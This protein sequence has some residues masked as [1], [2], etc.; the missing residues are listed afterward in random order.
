MSAEIVIR[1]LQ[2]TKDNTA[3]RAREFFCPRT[4]GKFALNYCL[5]LDYVGELGVN[6][7]T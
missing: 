1:I 7:R 5:L 6:N 3:G 2:R 4:K